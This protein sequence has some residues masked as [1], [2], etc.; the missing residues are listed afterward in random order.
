MEHNGI[1]QQLYQGGTLQKYRS[2]VIGDQSVVKF[3]LYELSSTLLCP[4]PGTFGVRMRQFFMSALFGYFGPHV[5]IQHDVAFRRPHQIRLGQG[6]VLESGVTLDIKGDTGFI[7]IHDNVHIGRNTILSCPGG[8]ITIGKGTCIGKNCRLGS[9]KG[10]TIGQY[11]M[12]NDNA[13]IIG[14]G[15]TYC[16]KELPIIKQPLTCSGPTVIEDYVEIGTEV[17]VLDGIHIGR[18][19]KI[20]ANSFVRKDIVPNCT[21]SGVPASP[22]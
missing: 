11:S 9:L 10:L 4:L 17:T 22:C 19:A 21:A 12:I 6:V 13:C 20:L 8:T 16:A 18:K 7:D 14:A 1:Q 2:T 3:L 5:I 15:H